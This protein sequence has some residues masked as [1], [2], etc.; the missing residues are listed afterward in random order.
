MKELKHLR[1][2]NEKHFLNDDGTI[3]LYL[4]NNDIHYLKN[5]EYLDIDNALIEKGNTII[6]KAN[7]FHTSFPKDKNTNLLVDITKDNYY[8]KIY[9]LKNKNN[10]TNIKRNKQDLIFKNILEDIDIDYKVIS[11]KLKESIILKNKNNIPSSLSFKIDTNLVLELATKGSILAKD[12]DKNIFVIDAPFMKD[13][14]GSYNYNINYDLN[15]KDNTY[16]LNLNLDQEWLKKAEFPVII[17]PTISDMENSSIAMDAYIY[18]WDDTPGYNYD[19]TTLKVGLDIEDS[20]K[21]YETLIKFNL[22]NIGTGFDIVNATASLISHSTDTTSNDNNNY[23]YVYAMEKDWNENNVSFMNLASS[24]N[25]HVEDF[26]LPTRSE[27]VG[28]N[29]NLHVNSFNITNMMKKWY[30]GSPNYGLILKTDELPANCKEYTFYSKDNEIIDKVDPKP[31]LVITYRNQNGLEDYMTYQTQEYTDGASYINNLTGNLTTV[32]NLNETISGKYPI[33]LS[34]IYN[35][36]DVV[37]NKDYGYKAGYKFNL[38]ETIEEV[39]IDNNNYLEYTDADGTIHYFRN[40]LDDEGNKIDNKYIDEDGLGL[41]ATKENND[42][43]VTDIDNNEYRFTLNN[44]IYYLTKLTNTNKDTVTIFYDSANRINKV[45]DANNSSINITYNTDNTV[46]SSDSTTTTINYTN[47]K[48]TNIVTKNGTTSFIYNNNGLIEKIIDVNG[49]SKYFTYYETSPYKVKKITEYGLNN[50]QGASLEFDYGFLV[51]RVKDNKNRYNTYI[52]NEQGN[53]I[54]I[55]NLNEE[56]NLNNAYGKGTVYENN[57]TYKENNGSYFEDVN[58][59]GNKI[60]NE[61]LAVKYTKNLIKNSS[62]EDEETFFIGTRTTEEKRTGSYSLK[63]SDYCYFED[64]SLPPRGRNYTFSGY[65][66]NDK[67]LT[68]SL[69]RRGLNKTDTLDIISIPPNEDFAKYSVTGDY[70]SSE[71]EGGYIS[72]TITSNEKGTAYLDDIQLE[73]GE[74]ANYY[75]MLENGDFHNGL[76]GWEVSAHDKNGNEYSNVASVVTLDGG[77]KALKIASNPD[78]D[79]S[80]DTILKVNGIGNLSEDRVGDLYNLSFWYKNEGLPK[81][82]SGMEYSNSVLLSFYYTNIPEDMGYGLDPIGLPS[83]NNEWQYFSAPFP[84]D[85]LYNYDTIALTIFSNYNANNLYIA[86]ITLSK[87]IE[88]SYNYHNSENGNLEGIR[89]MD[90]SH[91]SFTYDENNQLT[92]MFNPLGNN[93]KFEYDN[94]VTDRVLKGISPSGISNEILYDDFGNP[95]KTLINN[96]NPDQDVID[97]KTYYIRLKGSQKYW[98]SNF[99]TNEISLKEDNCSHDAYLLTKEGDY[100]RI[101]SG[102]E[103][104]TLINNSIGLTKLINDD[105]LFR[106]S[107]QNNNSYIIIPKTK[108]NTLLEHNL[109]C[110]NDKLSLKTEDTK[111]SEEQFYFEDIDTQLFIESKAE[112]TLDGKFVTKT[113]DSLDKVTTYDINTTNGLTN[114][115]TDANNITTYYTYNSKDQITKVQKENKEVNYTYNTNNLLSKITSNNKEYNFTYDNFLNAKQIKIGDNITLITNNY[116][117]NNGNLLSSVY[118]NGDT[119]SYTYDEL[120]RIKTM[121]NDINTYTYHY[122]NLGNLAKITSLNENYDYYYDLSSRISKYIANNFNIEYDYDSNNNILKKEYTLNN[123]ETVTFEYNTDDAITKVTFDNNNLNYTYDYLGRLTSKDINGNQKIEYTYITNGNK[124]STVL[125]SMKINND[126]YEYYYDNLYN[127][128]DIYLNKKLINHYEYDNFNEL[129]KEDDYNLNKTIRYTYDNAGNIL[130]KQEYELDT[131]NLLHT[132]TYEYNNINWEDQL[133]K[134]NNESITYDEIGNPLTIGNKVLSWVNGRQ[135]ASYTDN[136]LSITYT[137]NKDGIRTQKKIN[138]TITNYF[139]E[140]NKI[141]FEQT[142]NNMIYYIRD[143]EGSLIGFKYNNTIYYCIKNMQEDII[144]LTDSNHNL[145]CS[146]EYDSWG[147]LISIKDNNGSIITDPSHIGYINPFRY[148][149]YYYDN[150]TK[151]YYLNSRYYNPEWGRFIN[152]DNYLGIDKNILSY[153]FYLYAINNPVNNS[154]SNGNFFGKVWSWVKKKANQVANAVAKAVNKIVSTVVSFQKR[155]TETVI[156]YSTSNDDSPI[157]ITSF[158]SQSAST[159]SN[160]I[161]NLYSNKEGDSTSYGL[162]LMVR[163]VSASIEASINDISFSF[164][165]SVQLT[166]GFDY[167]NLYNSKFYLIGSYTNDTGTTQGLKIEIDAF[168]LITALVFGY[169]GYKAQSLISAFGKTLLYS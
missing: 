99:I 115:I 168:T 155:R 84:A 163:N 149:S 122:D 98:D 32:F 127:I 76:E 20:S 10:N 49:L 161:I 51:T 75:N 160:K 54:G 156:N 131:Y 112:Y 18:S 89:N 126:L 96:V 129:I 92:S 24:Y 108:D 27:I 63:F 56:A 93:F 33:N 36:N 116:E 91:T 11:T 117:N 25:N 83:H 29:M 16:Y 169:Y 48:I 39:T 70:P 21:I 77:V 67:P 38:N 19:S 62:F 69:E 8:L 167:S 134:Y 55:T 45:T 107:L 9:L 100:Y 88:Q 65:F 82:G 146:Y 144:G 138:N 136:D 133:T 104:V 85:S 121:T 123:Q 4:Y 166:A 59:A 79:I 17:D 23:I 31:Y 114:S 162:E 94:T 139:T 78:L 3:S 158:T 150:E 37:L 151:L 159:S 57:T 109:A 15:L 52:F 137:Y 71:E 61:I 47:N 35:T 60:A 6:N 128:T 153:N 95:I 142:G 50:E 101:K 53:T 105:S 113:I 80:V 87:D 103:Y 46:I 147:K 130:K 140:N 14:S 12:K 119:F 22:P 58:R 164:G 86:N 7:N 124:T 157:N 120:D 34:L 125:N 30:S 132:D 141:I 44:N 40:E 111:E 81:S 13:N 90:S 42:Y 165:G 64:P 68:M 5:G 73:E 26:F 72:V 154:D 106:L 74:I 1:K 28:N 43:K 152:C 135:L 110:V 97:G 143:E 145:L 118:G 148:R 41:K 66:K 102:E 2:R